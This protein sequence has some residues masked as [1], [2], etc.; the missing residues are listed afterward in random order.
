[1]VRRGTRILRP[2]L[3]PEERRRL[4]RLGI[5]LFNRGEFFAAHEA[6]EEI[7]RSDRPEPRDL[8]QGLVQVAAGLHHWLDR[9]KAAPARRVM[10]RGRR[11]LES[12][13]P[14]CRGL[15]LAS[16]AA[17]VEGWERWL[18]DAAGEPPA[19]PRLVVLDPAALA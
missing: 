17:A 10:A 8:F 18:G 14:A 1:V 12:L 6:W 15:D 4:F 7:W 16:L 5:N 13:D 9:G 3:T 19:P 2:E 11:R